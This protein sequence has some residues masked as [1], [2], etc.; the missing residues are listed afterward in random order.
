MPIG[1][2][3][4]TQKKPNVVKIQEPIKKN[5]AAFDV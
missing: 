1:S 4:Q 3:P 5:T 2:G